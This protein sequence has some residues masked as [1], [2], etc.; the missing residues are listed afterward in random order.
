MPFADQSD[1]LENAYKALSVNYRGLEVDIYEVCK[2]KRQTQP[3]MAGDFM[4]WLKVPTHAD[5]RQKFETFAVF[6]Y[7]DNRKVLADAKTFTSGFIKDGLGSF[8]G[9]DGLIIL[10]MDGAEHKKTRSLL[11]PVFMPANVNQFKD[12]MY[13]CAREDFL[14]HIVDDKK[15]NLMDFGL[16][17][18][19]RIIYQLMGFPQDATDKFYDYAAMGLKILAGQKIDPAEAEKAR[20]EANAVSDGLLTLVEDLVAQRR[21]EGS[22]GIDLISQLVRA[23]H[24]GERLSDFEIATF[25]RTLVAAGGETTSRTFSSTMTLLLERPDLLDRARK[26]R[27]LIPAII[28]EAIRFEPVATVKVRQ[29]AVD[30]E[31]GGV[32]IPA[33]SM[34]QCIVASANRDE[35]V[36]ERP[37]EFDPDRKTPM[38]FTFGFGPHMCIGQFIAKLELEAAINAVF[39]LLPNIRLDPDYPAPKIQGGH[40][41]GAGDIHVLWD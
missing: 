21:A 24:E 3:V 18:P 39:D 40:L 15:A 17:Y 34:V 16:Y 36:M 12:E 22:E 10:A 5:V 4:R 33:G 14:N 28:N 13:R 25:L 26:D 1:A 31:I 41:R 32:K 35:G 19:V 7:E 27:T 38:S 2:E 20:E 8:F 9:G 11:Q 23:E 37:N 6:K 30:T 29:A